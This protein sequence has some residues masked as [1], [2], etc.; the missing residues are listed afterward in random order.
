[1]ELGRDCLDLWGYKRIEEIVWIKTNQ[2]QRIIRTGRTGH[3]LNHS[4]EHC[5]VGIKGN[6]KINRNI[7]CDVIVSEVRETSRKPDEIY[8]II[9]RMKPGGVKVELFARPHNRMPGW[10][11]VGNQLPGTFLVESRIKENFKVKHPE[12]EILEK[13]S[14]SNPSAAGQWI[15]QEDTGEQTFINKIYFNHIQKQKIG[16][17]LSKPKI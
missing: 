17:K 4:K 10:I 14:D 3:W 5:L 12:M 11:S 6:P 8:R 2:L 9:E 15:S 7:D 16:Q 1:M 13:G